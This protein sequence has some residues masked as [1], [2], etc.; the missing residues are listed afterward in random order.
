MSPKSIT[1][2]AF[3]AVAVIDIALLGVWTYFFFMLRSEAKEI[4]TAA[5]RI[6]ELDAKGKGAVA[7]ERLLE[8]T[9]SERDK[10]RSYFI[11]GED[12][13]VQFYYTLE[14]LADGLGLTLTISGAAVHAADAGG[15]PALGLELDLEGTFESITHF[16]NLIERMPLVSDWSDAGMELVSSGGGTQDAVWKARL[17][18]LISSYV[19]D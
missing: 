17:S 6:A 3:A 15:A 12:D 19:A 2:K 10:I 9:K 7:L 16:I 4:E 8:E 11:R 1:G 18:L 5:A 13:T 14:S